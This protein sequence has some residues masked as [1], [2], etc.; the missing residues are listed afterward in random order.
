MLSTWRAATTLD[1][2]RTHMDPLDPVPSVSDHM[3]LA[4]LDEDGRRAFLSSADAASRSPLLSS[5]LRQLGGALADEVAGGGAFSRTEGAFC[6]YG[7]GVPGDSE[8]A[9]A[10]RHYLA[11]TRT[12]LARWDTGRILPTFVEDRANPGRWLNEERAAFVDLVRRGIDPDGL[13]RRDIWPALAGADR[14]KAHL[15]QGSKERRT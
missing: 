12:A 15:P 6:Y 10:M 9:G 7:L 4:E 13:F 2:P 3:V 1:V 14:P 11:Q 5:E 8:K